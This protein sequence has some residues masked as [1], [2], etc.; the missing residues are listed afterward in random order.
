[1]CKK[2]GEAKT[3]LLFRIQLYTWEQVKAVLEGN[4]GVRRTLDYYAHRAFKS[5]LGQAQTIIQWGTRMDR[6]CGNL[7]QVALKN[8]GDLA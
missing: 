4:H 5:K 6:D 8:M 3:K 2:L 7:Q 1:V